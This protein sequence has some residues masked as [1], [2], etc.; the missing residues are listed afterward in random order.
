M[1]E[2]GEVTDAEQVQRDRMEDQIRS[3]AK[4]VEQLTKEEGEWGVEGRQGRGM[5]VS[6][7][8]QSDHGTRIAA[9][10]VHVARKVE[11]NV[12][13]LLVAAASPSSRP[14]PTA[15][16]GSMVIKQ[17]RRAAGKIHAAR[18]APAS[19]SPVSSQP[20]IEVAVTATGETKPSKW[21]DAAPTTATPTRG[22][23]MIDTGAAVTVVTK[24]WADAHG[25]RVSAPSGV[26]IRGAGGMELSV[27]GTTSM[28]LQLSATLEVDVTEVTVSAGSFYQGLLGC[29]ILYGKPGILGPATV[30]LGGPGVE[31][32]LQ[33]R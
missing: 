19:A 22:H 8:L 7:V 15:A 17:V 10:V 20:H 28:T 9:A 12:R 27:V 31:G 32:S 21:E 24:A 11:N 18:E 29:D 6:A 26:S 5:D 14:A 16:Q 30:Q 25:L 23:M 33:W 3:I 2:G 13:D 1:G 4:A